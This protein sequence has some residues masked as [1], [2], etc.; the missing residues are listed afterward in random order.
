[1]NKPSDFKL[2]SAPGP[3]PDKLFGGGN[4]VH[5]TEPHPQ[6]VIKLLKDELRRSQEHVYELYKHIADYAAHYEKGHKEK[7]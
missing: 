3:R 4:A 7:K 5:E 1:M 2:R 6:T